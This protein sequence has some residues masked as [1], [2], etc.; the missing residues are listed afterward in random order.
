MERFLLSNF[1]SGVSISSRS[2]LPMRIVFQPTQTAYWQATCSSRNPSSKS[3]SIS[4]L[5]QCHLASTSCRPFSI[6]CSSCLRWRISNK[7]IRAAH[8]RMPTRSAR[9]SSH[10]ERLSSCYSLCA[11]IRRKI[12]YSFYDTSMTSMH[13]SRRANR[14]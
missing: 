1:F 8:L 9:G 5:S 2:D 6:S 4:S 12:L 3:V 7:N 10:E 14:L 13:R 11:H